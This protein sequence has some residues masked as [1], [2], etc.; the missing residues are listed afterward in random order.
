MKFEDTLVTDFKALEKYADE[1]RKWQGIPSI[2][3]TKKGR[4]F[5]TFYSGGITEQMGN[6]C[7]LYQ[8]DDGETWKMVA[9]AD[10]GDEFR[11]YDA[12][13]WTDPLGRVWFIW[14]IM[15]SYCVVASLI[16]DPDA[17]TL[18]FTTPRY[19]GR[20]IML[21][22]PIVTKDDR[23]LFPIAV[24]AATSEAVKGYKSDSEPRLACV[25]E[26][27]DHGETFRLIGGADADQR[28]Y[29]EHM[30]LEKKD[31]SIELY[32]RTKYGIAKSVSTDGG[33]TWPFAEDSG[34]K[35]PCSR[36]FIGR[37]K[38]GNVLLV[39]H[40]NFTYRNNL[41]AHISRDGGKTWEG[42]LLLDE[43]NDVSYPDAVEAEDGTIFVVYDRQRGATYDKSAERAR[44]ILMARFTEEDVLNG[45]IVSKQ[46]RLKQIVSKLHGEK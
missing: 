24:W 39:N 22:K 19:I 10:A 18:Q 42:G 20:D 16:E 15:P 27:L 1:H 46:G 37:L 45:K 13:L 25:Y 9:C 44:E 29:D 6:Y 35:G 43:R 5:V 3:M 31:G 11:C 38:S 32:M 41:T 26:S 14:S 12:A 40:F 21:N 17:E 23:W 28:L 34:I 7:M 36:F 4:L 2:T 30:L 8:S 33:K